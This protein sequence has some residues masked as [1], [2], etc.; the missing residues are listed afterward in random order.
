[1]SE[2][3]ISSAL[4]KYFNTLDAEFS[5]IPG[6]AKR[7]EAIELALHFFEQGLREA[8]RVLKLDGN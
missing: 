1:M 5:K 8:S 6:L 3:Q 2:E 7:Q 4:R